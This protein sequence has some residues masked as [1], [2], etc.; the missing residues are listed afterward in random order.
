MLRF[1]ADP[2]EL[3][4]IRV[5]WVDKASR[6]LGPISEPF[7]YM[8]EAHGVKLYKLADDGDEEAPRGEPLSRTNLR[9]AALKALEPC[10]E[11]PLRVLSPLGLELATADWNPH[12][13][14]RRS[15]V[16]PWT[17]DQAMKR[18]AEC[19]GRSVSALIVQA[20]GEY[21]QRRQA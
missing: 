2:V 21:L 20:V 17:F 14:V 9:L 5:A 11:V 1:F 3:P 4:R 12:E 19:E 13:D 15:F 18:Q 6:V 16:V 10:W 8:E 7:S